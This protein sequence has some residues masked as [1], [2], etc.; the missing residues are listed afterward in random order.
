MSDLTVVTGR[1][2]RSRK[3]CR[4]VSERI[5]EIASPG[6]GRW[7]PAWEIVRE[8][9]VRLLDALAAW[10]RTGE[11]AAMDR[12]KDVAVEVV[13]AWHAAERASRKSRLPERAEVATR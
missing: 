2:E 12:A 7:D 9:S 6:L 8:S 11:E 1:R 13:Q 4:I 3:L 10:E 5:G